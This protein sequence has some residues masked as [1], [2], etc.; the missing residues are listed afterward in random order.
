MSTAVHSTPQFLP[1][2]SQLHMAYSVCRGIAR[3]Q[4]KNFYYGFLVLPKRKRQA[5]CAVYAFMRRCDDI[6]DDPSLSASERR[7]KLDAWVDA[8][9]AAQ[10]GFATD[11]PVLIAL[12]DAQRRFHIP[13]GLLDGLAY[14]TSMDV[15]DQNADEVAASGLNIQY[16]SFQDLERYCYHVASVVG[17]VCI[18]IFGYTDP[19]AEPLAERCGLAFQLTNI[20]RDV[21]EDAGLGRIYLPQEDLE[22]FGVSASELISGPDLNRVRPLLEIEAQR[23]FE[24]YRAGE[25]LLP[26]ISEDS[27]PALW[28]LINIY[29][30]LLEKIVRLN[31]DVFSRRVS[32]TTREKL[33]ILSKGFL[34]R[35][36]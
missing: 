17:L 35:I 10:A 14:G 34:K 3:S 28:V 31:Y 19:A 24:N 27:Q 36:A 11:D 33:I 4:A 5:L 32:L 21:K 23:A 30:G 29:R 13:L 22:Q 20:I 15:E 2:E 1:T 7:Q 9:H 8:F 26:M 12:T 16:R 6:S 18:R 25:Q